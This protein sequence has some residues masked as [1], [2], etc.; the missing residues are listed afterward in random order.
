MEP[1]AL[2]FTWQAWY[3]YSF[4][5]LRR[6]F[7]LFKINRIHNMQTVLSEKRISPQIDLSSRPWT[8]NW[9]EE[10]CKLIRF[11]VDKTVFGRLIDFF[12]EKTIQQTDGGRLLVSAKMPVG[13]WIISYL[14]SLPGGVSVIEPVELRSEILERARKIT[15]KNS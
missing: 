14:M 5:R 15:E 6:D 8:E 2:V 10:S 3:V 7:R 12:D 13:E 9:P 11:T 1:L 4:C